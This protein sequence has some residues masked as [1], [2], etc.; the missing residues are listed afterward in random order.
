MLVGGGHS[1]AHRPSVLK[2]SWCYGISQIVLF[3]ETRATMED[4]IVSGYAEMICAR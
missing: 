2:N 1:M 4:Y 3:S